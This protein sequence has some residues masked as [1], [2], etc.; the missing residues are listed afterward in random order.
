MSTR[1]FWGNARCPQAVLHPFGRRA[2]L[3]ILDRNTRIARCGFAIFHLHVDLQIVV[4]D[5]ESAHVGPL[6]LDGLALAFEISR[7]IARYADMRRRIDTVGSQ[8]DADDI[9]V[10]Q[11]Q[12]LPGR[13]ADFRV[14]RQLH[15]ALMRSSDTQFVLGAEHPERLHA[16]ILLRL[17]LNSSSPPLG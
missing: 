1:L 9:V 8:T 4:I 14:G 16:R 13:L 15:D 6:Q 5:G 7:Q 10:F 12:V 3:T 17:I 11:L 2:Y